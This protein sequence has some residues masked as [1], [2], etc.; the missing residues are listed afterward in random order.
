MGWSG[1]YQFDRV[2][3]GDLTA[4]YHAH[5]PMGR[6]TWPQPTTT[7]TFHYL[8]TPGLPSCERACSIAQNAGNRLFDCW[9]RW[10][11]RRRRGGSVF[12]ELVPDGL[13]S[14]HRGDWYIVFDV[15][16][17]QVGTKRLCATV[18]LRECKHTSWD[19]A[20]EPGISQQTKV[21][22]SILCVEVLRYNTS[23]ILVVPS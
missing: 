6:A 15:C 1:T 18:P 2:S 17:G 8:F 16:S 20:D 13:Q 19:P 23:E 7:P 10:R 12:G 14:D 22:V 9:R 3:L 21:K 11:K 4:D 5:F